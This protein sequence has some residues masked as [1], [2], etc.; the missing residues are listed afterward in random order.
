MGDKDV[1]SK[2]YAE[3]T[4]TIAAKLK[5]QPLLI[6]GREDE[7]RINELS[8]ITKSKPLNLSGKTSLLQLAAL[9]KKVDL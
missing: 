7:V 2:R 5:A 6:G 9:L 4:D 1:A 8:S 3:L